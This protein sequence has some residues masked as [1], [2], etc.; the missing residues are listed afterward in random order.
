MTTTCATG[1]LSIFG[2]SLG[3]H[4]CSPLTIRLAA[5]ASAR[6]GRRRRSRASVAWVSCSSLR[7]RLMRF[8]PS[9]TRGIMHV[10]KAPE[11]WR[12]NLERPAAVHRSR[13]TDVGYL[14]TLFCLRQGGHYL[15]PLRSPGGSSSRAWIG[16]GPDPPD[17]PQCQG[18]CH[19]YALRLPGAERALCPKM[20]DFL[21]GDRVT[22]RGKS[23]TDLVGGLFSV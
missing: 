14:T 21:A 20:H 13:P 8:S 4:G 9:R 19:G 3:E 15:Q 16:A 12:R 22:A 11:T 6:G 1:W 23:V 5:V 2:G 18:H 7:R 17:D 10:C